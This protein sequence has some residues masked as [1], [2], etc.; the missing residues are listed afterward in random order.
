L[1][2]IDKANAN[3]NKAQGEIKTYNQAYNDAIAAQRSSQNKIIS[4]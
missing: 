2:I 4:A 1:R 3:K